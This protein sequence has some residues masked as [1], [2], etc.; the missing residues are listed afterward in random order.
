[1]SND[2]DQARL[3]PA[4]TAWPSLPRL[5]SPPVVLQL[6]EEGCGA[7]CAV[8]LL[9]DRGFRVDQEYFASELMMPSQPEDISARLNQLSTLN[10]KGGC[11]AEGVPVSW[12]LLDFLCHSRGSW[13]ALLQPR[14]PT[15]VGHW[16]VVDSIT[17]EGLVLVRDPAA[18]AHGIPLG[19]FAAVW[20]YTALVLQQETP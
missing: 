4:A 7:A 5:E 2:D 15:S 1:M 6:D 10:W 16:V 14:G 3:P 19:D 18:G 12:E 20:G 9:A 8:M 13:A 17:D 11:L